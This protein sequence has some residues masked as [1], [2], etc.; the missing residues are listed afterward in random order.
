MKSVQQRVIVV[1]HKHD[2]CYTRVK[3]RSRD[4][5][6]RVI[7]ACCLKRSKDEKAF[8]TGARENV[9]RVAHDKACVAKDPTRSCQRTLQPE[10][11]V[12]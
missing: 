1:R 11:R 12:R 7:S 9:A 2:V 10:Y 8:R 3:R 4:D 6:W 5:R